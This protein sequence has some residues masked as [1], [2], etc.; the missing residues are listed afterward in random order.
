MM[1]HRHNHLRERRR[2]HPCRSQRGG[3]DQ[4]A[5]GDRQA[6]PGL[7]AQFKRRHDAGNVVGIGREDART[8][9]PRQRQLRRSF[10][11]GEHVRLC[12]VGCRGLRM[13]PSPA[14]AE[15]GQLGV[16][17]S[18]RGDRQ[19][20]QRGIDRAGQRHAVLLTHNDK[21]QPGSQLRV[22][23]G[24]GRHEQP[25]EVGT[26]ELD[27]GEIGRLEIT[28]SGLRVPPHDLI[29]VDPH[30]IGGAAQPH[31]HGR[32]GRAIDREGC[33]QLHDAALPGTE[34]VEGSDRGSHALSHPGQEGQ[35]RGCRGGHADRASGPPA[36]PARA[37]GGG[38]HCH[39]H[40]VGRL[41][42]PHPD[43]HFLQCELAQP[44]PGQHAWL[45]VRCGDARSPEHRSIGGG[46]VTGPRA[47]ACDPNGGRPRTPDSPISLDAMPFP[48]PAHS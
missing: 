48:Q 46:A 22:R 25:G 17:V 16:R 4:I 44:R 2:Q 11:G 27:A 7:A 15:V 26:I 14:L 23:T 6:E 19:H 38:F 43:R 1:I 39:Q 10:Q 29:S 47:G 20:G 24:T 33:A 21:A 37:V 13:R 42:R 5:V 30:H 40:P 28:G 18:R 32:R 34:S 12:T 45:A 9:Q 35:R 36:T 8:D 3:G 31:H 41:S